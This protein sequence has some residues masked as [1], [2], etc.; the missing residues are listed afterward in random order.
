MQALSDLFE[1][2]LESLHDPDV[3]TGALAGAMGPALGILIEAGL[4]AG[5]AG[6]D[7]PKPLI[8]RHQA[9]VRIIEASL[10]FIEWLGGFETPLV[11]F[12]D[13]WR[14]AGPEGRAIVEAW[15]TEASRLSLTVLLTERDDD[16]F[17]TDSIRTLPLGP[18]T[19]LERLSL[20]KA[21]LGPAGDAVYEWFGDACPTLPF[22]ILA[23]AR[24]LL[25]GGAVMREELGWRIDPDLAASLGRDDLA[26]TL[27]IRLR[28]G[29]GDI[30]RTV[31]ACALWGDQA[32]LIPLASAL[33]RPSDGLASEIDA[34]QGSGVLQRRDFVI[35]FLHDRLR[36]AVLAVGAGETI[37]LAAAMAASLV[38]E[39]ALNAPDLASVVLRL[40]L[41]AGEDGL[42]P[43]VWRD[44]FANGARS[45]RLGMNL[46]AAVGF[47][48]AACRLRERSPA[49][50]EGVD[51]LIL[52]EGILAAADR[53]DRQQAAWRIAE[54][55]KLAAT[56]A[57]VGEDY[58]LA[59]TALRLVSDSDEAWRV[60]REGL[61]RLGLR[62]PDRVALIRLAFP[63]VRWWLAK[64]MP[65]P[66]SPRSER[67]VTVDPLSRIGNVAGTM[68]YERSPLISAYL[69]LRGGGT[70][71]SGGALA[72]ANDTFLLAMIGDFH[73]AAQLGEQA[74][75]AASAPDFIGFARAATLYRGLYWGVV[76]R[77]PQSSIRHRCLEIRDL[78]LAEGDLIQAAVA[79][80]NWVMIG[81]RTAS[82][83][84]D[85]GRDI[86]RARAELVR[87]GD[88]HVQALVSSVS[89]AVDSL[90]T[91]TTI[92]GAA[93]AAADV[94][95]WA[96]RVSHDNPLVVI[97]LANLYGDWRYTRRI[98]E[99]TPQFR[100]HISL[101]PRGAD[102]RFQDGLAR[103]KCGE[104]LVAADIRY[105]KKVARLNPADNRAKLLVLRAE[106]LRIAGRKGACLAAYAA[107]A[108]AAAVGDSRLEAG[109]AH[110]CAA[111]AARAFGECALAEH[112]EARVREIWFGWGA[113]A[114]LANDEPK[115]PKTPSDELE[116][117]LTEA[118]AQAFAADRAARARSRFL[119]DVAHEL[120]T[121]LQGMQGLIDLAATD[122]SRLDLQALGE[123]FASLK[124]VV[125][126]LT[127]FGALASGEASVAPA[128]VSLV[129]LVKSEC[130]IGMGLSGGEAPDPIWVIG[131]GIP[132]VVLT[133]GPRV[134]QVVRNLLSNA[135]KYG[136]AGVVRISLVSRTNERTGTREIA[137]IVE[138]EGPGL[139]PADLLHIFEPFERGAKAGDGLGLGLG[140]ALSRRIAIALGG[141]LA[142]E[143]RREGGARFTFSFPLIELEARPSLAL[144]ASAAPALSILLAED[145]ALVRRV[146][147]EILRT[148]G[149][150]ITEAE[151]GIEAL[152]LLGSLDFDIAI[153]DLGMPGLS[154]LDVFV[155]HAEVKKGRPIP[156]VILLTA[157]GDESV[158]EK[159]Q[160]AGVARLLRKP[161]TAR[162]IL[163]A[164]NEVHESNA[165][166]AGR[167]TAMAESFALLHG[168]ARQEIASR[169]DD[170]C[171]GVGATPEAL[172]VEAHRLAGLAAQFGWPKVA[173]AADAI[174]RACL[175]G[176]DP[177]PGDLASLRAVRFELV[178]RGEIHDREAEDPS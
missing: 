128:P 34:I 58:E 56:E 153:L 164:V 67:S 134:R 168:Q 172:A 124:R 23:S 123:V 145:V 86:Q 137:L 63:F 10:R 59:I 152:S 109:I 135:A 138:D 160:G 22:D 15:I 114:L 112:Y 118:R 74:V 151:D 12:I 33:A 6:P 47:A 77:R 115:Q 166:H 79:I 159:A 71:A 31:L 89:T 142:A 144:P 94:P 158:E 70:R 24:A 44:R 30:W 92:A 122:P 40:R 141:G 57:E 38:A 50:D 61:G 120:R 68:A 100:G 72:Q 46:D 26:K 14:R 8:G 163:D 82:S 113:H 13:D 88:P 147:V 21:A 73:G 98:V 150:E 173:L 16:D 45:A 104:R 161:V 91:R 171:E 116:I 102:W 41:I 121:P 42:D 52:R 165:A 48:E 76:W 176:L 119:A 117:K 167:P 66:L 170:L 27:V 43:E 155:Q 103:L 101:H 107:A 1:T 78:A 127:D 177:A 131:P 25:L 133:D 136:G 7:H 169:I 3:V 75:A 54:L 175:V 139:A 178:E 143:N 51:R 95:V 32:P 90:T 157:S 18:L 2:A 55:F 11:L 17:E 125:N 126:D 96:R 65:K 53:G 105:L 85:L 39:G 81:W 111:Q 64:K 156:P 87:L 97:E 148:G 106:R 149:H 4:R 69:V 99:Q 146:L 110:Q 35:G 37:G 132:E 83:L 108:E 80:R 93:P 174:E 20:L 9:V 129:S 62:V 140:L 130:A 36:A 60:S 162:E 154:G 84:T 28:D 5:L 49:S 19:E 29:G